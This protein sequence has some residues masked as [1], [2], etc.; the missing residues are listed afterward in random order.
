MA[1][2]LT[3]GWFEIGPAIFAGAGFMFLLFP[4]QVFF[5]KLFAILRRKTSKCTDARVSTMKDII[6]GIRSVRAAGWEKPFSELIESLR[7]AEITNV[8][9]VVYIKSFNSSTFF[10]AV[11]ISSMI[12]MLTYNAAGGN[13]TPAKVFT[14]FS[15]LSVLRVPVGIMLPRWIQIANEMRNTVNRMEAILDLEETHASGLLSTDGP[16]RRSTVPES[17]EALDISDLQFMWRTSKDPT[18]VHPQ[19]ED[20][21]EPKENGT[22]KEIATNG[23]PLEPETPILDGV[24]LKI[25]FG[26]LAVVRGPVGSGKSTLLSLIL[27]E[28]LHQG[29]VITILDGCPMFY[30]PQVPWIFPESIRNNI[31]F[32]NRYD[33][34]VFKANILL[35]SSHLAS[36]PALS[37]N[38]DCHTHL[39][40]HLQIYRK[41]IE[42]CQLISDL[43]LFQ[44]GDRAMVGERGITLSGGQKARVSLARAVYG[45]SV[46]GRRAIV[47]LDDPLSAVDARVGEKLYSRVIRGVLRQHAVLLVTHHLRFGKDADRVLNLG[48]DL[49]HLGDS[50]TDDKSDHEGVSRD[51]SLTSQ[52]SSP[53]GKDAHKWEGDQKAK[54]VIQEEHRKAGSLS[55]N[56]YATYIHSSGPVLVIIFTFIMFVA[57][58]AIGVYMELSLGRWAED[59]DSA[60]EFNDA[61]KATNSTARENVPDETV[62]LSI[63]LVAFLGLLFS[64]SLLYMHLTVKSSRRIHDKAFVGLINTPLRFFDTQP[65]GRILN[66]FSKDVDYIDDLMPDTGMDTLQ[67]ALQCLAVFAVICFIDPYIIL[68]VTPCLVIFYMLRKIYL[69]ASREVKRIE[70][71]KRSPLYAHLNMAVDGLEIVRTYPGAAERILAQFSELHDHHTQTWL[72]YTVT[73]RWLGFRL[74]L[75]MSFLAVATAFSSVAQRDKI[76]TGGAGLSLAY[77]TQLAGIVQWALRQSAEFE[78]QITAVERLNEYARLPS[79]QSFVGC[80]GAGKCSACNGVERNAGDKPWTPTEAAIEMRDVRLW[81]SDPE[82]PVLHGINISIQPG[83]KVGVVGRT[84]AGKSSLIAVLLR[85]APTSGS[86]KIDGTPTCSIPLQDLRRAFTL[87]PQ[88]PALFAGTIRKNLD[89][90]STCSDSDLWVAIESAQLKPVIEAAGGLEATVTEAGGNFSVGERQLICL[91]RAVLRPTKLLLLDE[92]TANVDMATDAIIQRVIRDRFA[93]CTVITIAHRLNT[94]LDSDFILVMDKGV[95]AEYGRPDALIRDRGSHLAA[96]GISAPPSSEI[97]PS[98]PPN[99][100]S[101][102]E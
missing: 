76:G 14:V 36:F 2:V 101:H 62:T 28:T 68:F 3:L 81:Y 92:A 10:G 83:S 42:A 65:V 34:K 70:G 46:C 75:I 40:A 32:G 48:S 18:K 50:D 5:G 9:H 63:L 88:D 55:R 8:F 35:V 29:G 37:S 47:L 59:V 53:T 33:E 66:R 71:V 44:D 27:G 95:V 20:G 102:A 39:T 21:K 91:A 49:T 1:A 17:T 38:T 82:T 6:D 96:F 74:D 80:G 43:L 89:P 90:F 77:S 19:P 12:S 57:T 22:A 25:R 61:A 100:H 45:A 64:R 26:E 97:V 13:P 31:I 41:T 84:G 79:E 58:Q 23:V 4:L 93:E 60:E 52:P 94:V 98:S 16:R 7:K 69:K 30:A 15:L 86:V 11:S 85:L 56:T 99:A 67:L 87:I 51:D 78:N 72:T 73:G 54:S 24:N